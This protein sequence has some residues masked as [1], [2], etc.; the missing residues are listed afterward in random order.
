VADN[1]CG[2][3]SELDDKVFIPFFTTKD[4]G[5]GIGL[6]LCRHIMNLHKGDI[7]YSSRLN[8]GTVFYLSF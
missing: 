4:G 5:S 7:S 3:S 6:S 2:I 1:G 8:E